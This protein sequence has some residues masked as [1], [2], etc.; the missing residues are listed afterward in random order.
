VG[1]L[2]AIAIAAVLS[3]FAAVAA[4]GAYVVFHERLAPHQ[5]R[6]V[7]ASLAGV[8]VLSLLQA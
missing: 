4:V 6:G 2:H 3:Q 5:R 7:G 8:A 1:A